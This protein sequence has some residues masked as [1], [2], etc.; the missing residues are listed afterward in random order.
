[1]ISRRTFLQAVVATVWNPIDRLK[2]PNIYA[3]W[4]HDIMNDMPYYPEPGR[5]YNPLREGKRFLED[6][7]SEFA[8][9]AEWTDE[10]L[11]TA[12]RYSRKGL[13]FIDKVQGYYDSKFGFQVDNE[14]DP[15]ITG[16]C[17]YISYAA[18][19][20][21]FRIEEEDKPLMRGRRNQYIL[22]A[23]DTNSKSILVAP[24]EKVQVFEDIGV[25][26]ETAFERMQSQY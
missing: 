9:N 20:A 15:M 10:V 26:L 17:Q 4:I 12:I 22:R 21:I 5:K 1:M 25:K 7:M 8:L 2:V 19:D 24:D 23:I 13:Y 6:A 18:H 14:S 3:K 16:V 11:D